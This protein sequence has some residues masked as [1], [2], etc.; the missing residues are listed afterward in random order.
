MPLSSQR[1]WL[2]GASSGIGEALIDPLVQAGARVAISARRQDLLRTL[3]DR[4]R[5]GEVMAVPVDVTDRAAVGTAVRHIEDRWGGIDL[6]ILN[7]GTHIPV[8]GAAIN[9]EDFETLIRAN[10][11]SVIYGAEAVLPGMLARG[12]GHLAGVASVAGYRALPTAAAYGASKAAA[13]VA[14]DAIRFD[15]EPRGVHVTVINP[16]F[17]RTPLTDK[18]TFSMPGLIDADAAAR[19]II[20]GLARRKKEIHFPAAFSWTMKALRVLPYPVFERLVSWTT[21]R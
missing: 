1:V 20:R 21:R 6:A 18:N 13:I 2:T 16:G 10:Y 4:Y 19:I 8:N 11:L 12:Q 5:G 7:A 3:A 17:V 9:A 14:L 15:V